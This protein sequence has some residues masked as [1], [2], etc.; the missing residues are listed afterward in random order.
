MHIVIRYTEG[1]LWEQAIKIDHI[2]CITYL[3]F[4]KGTDMNVHFSNKAM[5]SETTLFCTY[6]TM[7][8]M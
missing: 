6:K 3:W 7:A 8:Y 1:I 5:L 2:P 4:L